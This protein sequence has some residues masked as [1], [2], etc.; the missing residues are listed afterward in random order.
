[1]CVTEKQR[2]WVQ[3]K[4]MRRV[5]SCR[6][7]GSDHNGF[8]CEVLILLPSPLSHG[9]LTSAT[10]K[11]NGRQPH[12]RITRGMKHTIYCLKLWHLELENGID[13]RG[14]DKV[15]RGE[16]KQGRLRVRCIV[17]KVH[18]FINPW[19]HNLLT[20]WLL[21][22]PTHSPEDSFNCK[23]RFLWVTCTVVHVSAHYQRDWLWCGAGGSQEGA[24]TPPLGVKTSEVA[25]ID[26]SP[27]CI[28]S[29]ARH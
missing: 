22:F 10:A 27:Q 5:H 25:R 18:P 7:V 9:R 4:G 3:Q 6:P 8:P 15:R 24:V 19:M 17:V 14:L 29:L 16:G 11:N 2:K 1:M 23:P 20:V 21:R 12:K 13:V 28:H 26:S